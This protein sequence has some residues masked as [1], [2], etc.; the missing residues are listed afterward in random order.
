M[1]YF[2]E[3]PLS[4]FFSKTKSMDRGRQW[5]SQLRTAF[6]SAIKQA[7]NLLK[8]SVLIET[9][10]KASMALEKISEERVFP[11]PNGG[12]RKFLNRLLFTKS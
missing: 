7:P 2:V 1:L 10:E 9:L 5:L 6:V 4:R 12:I 11:K 3:N 8:G